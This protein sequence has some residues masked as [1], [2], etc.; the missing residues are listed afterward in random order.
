[1][2]GIPQ[3]SSDNNYYL[4]LDDS[5]GIY[6]VCGAFQG[7]FIEREGYVYQQAT[8]DIKQTFKYS[9]ITSENFETTV[10]KYIE[11]K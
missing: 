3:L 4:M 11:N 1:M 7:R 10:N 2:G 8:E 6:Y 9:P 5:N